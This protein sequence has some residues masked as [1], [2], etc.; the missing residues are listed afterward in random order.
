MEEKIRILN[1]QL[2]DKMHERIRLTKSAR[3]SSSNLSVEVTRKSSSKRKS[4]SSPL[5]AIE[6]RTAECMVSP[7]YYSDSGV[8]TS[9]T[10]VRSERNSPPE[11]EV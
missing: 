5:R 8:H 1:K 6:G 3:K 2:K 4:S 11:Y 9:S 10:F 7:D